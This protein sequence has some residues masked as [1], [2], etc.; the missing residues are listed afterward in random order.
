MVV[1]QVTGSPL[2]TEAAPGG[3]VTYELAGSV[4][5]AQAILD[6]WHAVR[7]YAYTNLAADFPFLLLYS[8]S[9]GLAC[10]WAGDV[11]CQRRW[12]FLAAPA[13]AL[14]LGQWLAAVFDAIE[15]VALLIM[16][17]AT[18]AAGPWPQIA[19]GFAVPKF[20]LVALGLLYALLGLCA[21]L[22]AKPATAMP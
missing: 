10:L 20:V 21:R 3:I 7:G 16:L 14:A 8:T 2:R 9:I 1:L 5:R 15:N 18:S 19:W 12:L 6:S 11:F 22:F 17:N 4:Q 13:T